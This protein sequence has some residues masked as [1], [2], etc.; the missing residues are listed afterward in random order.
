MLS[1]DL[2]HGGPSRR[3][4][5]RAGGGL[6][7]RK[8]VTWDLEEDGVRK[9]HTHMRQR[10]ADMFMP[11]SGFMTGWDDFRF[12]LCLYEVWALPLRFSLGTAYNRLG[13]SQ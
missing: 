3:Y 9:Q 11:D 8:N 5:R 1:T 6:R 12:L 10:L 2:D 7:R 13:T 4:V